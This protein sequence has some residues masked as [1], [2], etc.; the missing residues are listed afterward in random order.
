MRFR[1]YRPFQHHLR[2]LG[3]YDYIDQH[4]YEGLCVHWNTIKAETQ[5]VEMFFNQISLL[6]YPVVSASSLPFMESKENEEVSALTKIN[7]IIHN[8]INQNENNQNS[9]T[10]DKSKRIAPK[11]PKYFNEEELGVFIV[12]NIIEPLF[13]DED[14]PKSSQKKSI[15]GQPPND[16]HKEPKYDYSPRYDR[17][18]HSCK[19]TDTHRFEN[20]QINFDQVQVLSNN[21]FV[22]G[23]PDNTNEKVND[24]YNLSNDILFKF[25]DDDVLVNCARYNSQLKFAN[26]IYNIDNAYRM[27]DGKGDSIS[28]PDKK[29]AK[30]DAKNLKD[31]KFAKKNHDRGKFPYG[32]YE[33]INKKFADAYQGK[34][35]VRVE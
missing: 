9:K 10:N 25:N 26:R 7:A 28:S 21:V 19:K 6:I 13:D 31:A 8:L 32:S 3:A 2:G 12:N 33:F 23:K 34:N 35:F 20:F 18:G 22:N 30:Y 15:I 17:Y 29:F 1:R 5:V 4:Q 27:Y 14:E 24:F 11:R 16:S